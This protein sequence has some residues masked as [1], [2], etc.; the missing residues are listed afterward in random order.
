VS[1]QDD[2]D[3]LYRHRFSVDDARRKMA[4][5]ADFDAI[6]LAMPLIALG[7]QLAIRARRWAFLLTVAS[8]T[9]VRTRRVVAPLTVGYFVNAVLPARL[10]EVARAVLVAQREHLP[11]GADRA[12]RALLLRS[13]RRSIHH[14]GG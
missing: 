12:C 8:A 1:D 3:Q 13:A 5:W 4:V 2:L 10:G 7:V 6:W 14:A 9:A 11:I